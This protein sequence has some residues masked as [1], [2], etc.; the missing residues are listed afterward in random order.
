MIDIHSHILPCIDDGSQSAEESR[1]LLEILKGQGVDAVVLTPHYYGRSKSVEQFLSERGA[2]AEKLK[3]ICP[4]GIEV[5]LGCECNISTSA[6]SNFGELRPL[7]IGETGYILTELS[8]EP[9]WTD[10][11]WSRLRRLAETGLVP[12]IAHAELYPA[13]QKNPQYV[14]GLMN[15]GCLIQVNCDSVL[16]EKL[17]PLVKAMFLHGQ[18]HCL[19]TDTHNL[20][21]RPPHYEQ[22]VEKL[23]ADLGEEAVERLQAN[24]CSVLADKRVHISRDAFSTPI[25]RTILRKYV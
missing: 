21:A 1:A 5:V 10:R 24:M 7:A 22:A 11:L 20:T 6:N 8:F 2:A 3:A 25:K 13:V 9:Q 18:A 4:E 19:G 12:I 23:K 16:D 14:L 15:E 17:Y